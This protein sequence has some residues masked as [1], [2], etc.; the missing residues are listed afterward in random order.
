MLC[1]EYNVAMRLEL[2]RKEIK[3]DPN[4]VAELAAYFTHAKLQPVHQALSLRSA[5]F[6]FFKLKNFATTA[7]FCRR[8]LEL[9]PSAKV[10]PTNLECGSHLVDI[11]HLL[12]R[13]ASHT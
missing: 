5:M 4:R 10:H 8:L 7:T 9:N 13:P 6:I 12:L 11:M 1:R 2:A 3:D